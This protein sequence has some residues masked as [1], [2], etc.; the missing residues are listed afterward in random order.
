MEIK[1]S[2][3][4]LEK[5]I[6]TIVNGVGISDDI[7]TSFQSRSSSGHFEY[8][9]FLTPGTRA[10]VIARMYPDLS[11]IVLND[12]KLYDLISTWVGSHKLYDLI[13]DDVIKQIYK[14]YTNHYRRLRD[15]EIRNIKHMGDEQFNKK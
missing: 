2:E 8:I 14:K 4:K 15:I 12:E 10:N 7:F 11:L 1:I 3:E 6:D 13:K 9:Q 5:I